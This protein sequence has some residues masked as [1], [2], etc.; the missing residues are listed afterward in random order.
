MSKS[1]VPPPDRRGARGTPL[2]V[3]LVMIAA[4][5]AIHRDDLTANS[6]TTAEGPPG[7]LAAC[8]AERLGAV[9]QMIADGVVGPEK[10][11]LFKDR[12]QALCHTQNPE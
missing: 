2:A 8:L 11:S 12:A 9:D 10:A 3:A 4:L 6:E 5:A 1:S 7:A